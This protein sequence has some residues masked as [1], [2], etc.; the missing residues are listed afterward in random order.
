MISVKVRVRAR[1]SVR[2]TTQRTV[3]HSVSRPEALAIAA[4]R[5]AMEDALTVPELSTS[6]DACALI[7]R[8]T[9]GGGEDGG[10]TD[11]GSGEGGDCGLKI[12]GGGGGEGGSGG[13]GGEGGGE[14][15]DGGDHDHTKLLIVMLCPPP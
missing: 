1:F 15:G 8:T 5:L 4:V 2:S 3:T 14:G 9:G 7:S 10:G 6:R 13:G 11:G 12:G